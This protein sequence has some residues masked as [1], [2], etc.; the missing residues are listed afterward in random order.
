MRRSEGRYCGAGWC[1]NCGFRRCLVLGHSGLEVSPRS[2]V[3]VDK[4]EKEV[5]GVVRCRANDSMFPAGGGG[6][7]ENVHV[8]DI[9]RGARSPS[10]TQVGVSFVSLVQRPG[11]GKWASWRCSGH[12]KGK[13]RRH[14]VMVE[15]VVEVDG[16]VT[17]RQGR[18]SRWDTEN[19]GK[20]R[21]QGKEAARGERPQERQQLPEAC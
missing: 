10:S 4:G 5:D 3:K 17:T 19:G 6:R 1:L 21:T 7:L 18:F 14:A 2:L 20:R 16:R 12:G 13:K 9:E 8:C 15:R 11:G